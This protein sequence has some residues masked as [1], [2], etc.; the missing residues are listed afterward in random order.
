MT[1]RITVLGTESYVSVLE[2][3]EQVDVVNVFRMSE[4]IPPVLEDAIKKEGIKSNLDAIRNIQKMLRE[5]RKKM[6]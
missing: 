6:E 5:K 1:L 4:D 2:I 3:P